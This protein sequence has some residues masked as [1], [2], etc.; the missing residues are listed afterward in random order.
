[1]K[2]LF[3]YIFLVLT[4]CNVSF[5]E[6]L[7]KIDISKSF[8]HFVSEKNSWRTNIKSILSTKNKKIF[9]VK[10]CRA[11]AVSEHPFSDHPGRYEFLGIIEDDKT[12]FIRTSATDGNKGNVQLNDP[13]KN[14]KY[15]VESN[16][17]YLSF[18]EVNEILLS[19]KTINIYCEIEYEYEGIKYSLISKCEYINYNTNK[20]DDKYLQPIMGYVPFI[21]KNQLR[22]GYVVLNVNEKKNGCLEFLL[23][24]KTA[25]FN[26]NQKKNLIKFF[27][28]KILNIF[29]F[30]MKKNDFT[31]LTS[32]KECK[33]NFFSYD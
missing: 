26:I 3:L 20:N 12:H 8:I 13:M 21:L 10:E 25:I 2:K 23:N 5:S 31:E 15:I 6:D 22:Y 7:S 32:I 14:K 24:E 11:E 4:W 28:K 16:V 27:I 9:L 17:N 1:M 29:I 19:G 18:E 33:I 30:F